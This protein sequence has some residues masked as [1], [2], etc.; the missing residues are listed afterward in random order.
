MDYSNTLNLTAFKFVCSVP[1]LAAYQPSRFGSTPLDFCAAAFW[2]IHLGGWVSKQVLSAPRPGNISAWKG[3]DRTRVLPDIS[4]LRKQ[5]RA[6]WQ[7][8]ILRARRR[9][10]HSAASTA[11]SRRS[12]AACWHQ[13]ERTIQHDSCSLNSPTKTCHWIY[14]AADKPRDARTQA[15]RNLY[16]I[17][18][19]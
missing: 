9:W 11:Q 2:K 6:P 17:F 16:T 5:P 13:T 18:E 8:A 15:Y 12:H 4:S 7:S 3:E 19:Y 14:T 1:S 10:A